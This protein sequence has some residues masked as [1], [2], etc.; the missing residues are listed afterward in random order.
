MLNAVHVQYRP[1][2]SWCKVY[3]KYWNPHGEEQYYVAHLKPNLFI[4]QLNMNDNMYV[5][6]N[7]A[8]IL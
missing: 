2:Y 3:Y 7:Y 6:Y 5:Q 8:V 4:K 1:T